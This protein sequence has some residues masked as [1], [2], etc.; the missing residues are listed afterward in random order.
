MRTPLPWFMT[1]TLLFLLLNLCGWNSCSHRDSTPPQSTPKA[2]EGPAPLATYDQEIDAAK[3]DEQ[4]AGSDRLKVLEAQKREANARAAKAEQEAKQWHQVSSQKDTQ[5][6]T[7][8]NHRRQV[9][10]YWLSGILILLALAATV[11]AIWQ[12]M[13]RKIAGGFAVACVAVAGLALFLAWLIP[14]L[15]WVGVSLAVIGVGAVVFWWIRDHKSLRQVVESVGAAKAQIPAFKDGY[16]EIFSKII[17]SN[18]DRN[19]DKV[20]A[21]IG[22]QATKAQAKALAAAHKVTTALP[23]V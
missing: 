6:T 14:Y 15:I 21:Y 12:P 13:L 8:Q 2:E 18:V 20:R 5:I 11:L 1:G 17:D 10:L 23:P 22:N 3:K 4:A 7:E 19:I 9:Q 16:R